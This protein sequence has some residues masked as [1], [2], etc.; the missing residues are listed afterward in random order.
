MRRVA[1]VQHAAGQVPRTGAAITVTW[2]KA[3]PRLTRLQR[4][5]LLLLL[6]VLGVFWLTM[7][8]LLKGTHELAANTIYDAWSDG[9][10]GCGWRKQSAPYLTLRWMPFT[11]ATRLDPKP[12]MRAFSL[13]TSELKPGTLNALDNFYMDGEDISGM[14]DEQPDFDTSI[15]DRSDTSGIDG[16]SNHPGDMSFTDLGVGNESLVGTVLNDEDMA[17]LISDD[18]SEEYRFYSEMQRMLREVNRSSKEMAS[19]RQRFHE[20]QRLEED[21][22]KKLLLVEEQAVGLRHTV[23]NKNPALQ[24]DDTFMRAFRMTPQPSSNPMLGETSMGLQHRR[25][26]ESLTGQA[27]T[28][29]SSAIAAGT[30]ANAAAGGSGAAPGRAS[31]G[32]SRMSMLMQRLPGWF[33]GTRYNLP[34]ATVMEAQRRVWDNRRALWAA[35]V[36]PIAICFDED[37]AQTG[38]PDVAGQEPTAV[39]PSSAAGSSRQPVG[40]A[41]ASRRAL[42]PIKEVASANTSAVSASTAHRSLALDGKHSPLR[43]MRRGLMQFIQLATSSYGTIAMVLVVL[44]EL[45]LLVSVMHNVGLRA[46]ALEPVVDIYADLK[47]NSSS[48]FSYSRPVPHKP[49]YLREPYM[50]T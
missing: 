29:T 19:L 41:P 4:A 10:L 43:M 37:G 23:M 31:M 44:L 26:L 5:K 9:W 18:G 13:L 39:A 36:A 17:R 8:L 34:T 50:P 15:V 20:R 11:L 48:W 7:D 28:S 33:A 40:K 21:M 6:L 16:V 32:L 35:W 49:I 38:T 47:D 45:W 25:L 30:Y 42:T 3:P 24:G 12:S 14:L 27:N 2:L 46:V 22:D 1:A